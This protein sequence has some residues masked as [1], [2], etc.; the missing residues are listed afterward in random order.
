[1]AAPKRFLLRLDPRLFDALRGWADD[2]LRS[3]NAQIEYLLAE[4]ARRAGRFPARRAKPSHAGQPPDASSN[5]AEG[6]AD[7]GSDQPEPIRRA[8]AET[9]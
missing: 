5:D 4:R 7:A 2:D 1:M 6:E 8:A 3:V 9:A